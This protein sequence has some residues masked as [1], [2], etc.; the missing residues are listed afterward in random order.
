MDPDTD[1]RAIEILARA[2]IRKHDAVLLCQNL[3]HG[4]FYLPGGHV[5][6]GESAAHALARE[7]EEEAGEAVRV[8]ECALVAEN[9]FVQAGKPRHELNLVFHV[10][11]TSPQ[12]DSPPT[13]IKSLESHISFA[14]VSRHKLA[15][16]DLRPSWLR[17]WIISQPP[18]SPSA[19]TPAPSWA[20]HMI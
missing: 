4:Y 3:K 9:S 16:T 5:E 15:S 6:F 18:S 20:S 11:Q 14:W 12:S 17:D 1:R 10:E 8:G 19:G 2:L 13:P 7:M